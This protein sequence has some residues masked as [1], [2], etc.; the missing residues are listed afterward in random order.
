[1]VSELGRG[2]PASSTGAAPSRA[3]PTPLALRPVRVG[4]AHPDDAV[5]DFCSG[6][7][8]YAANLSRIH[9]ITPPESSRLT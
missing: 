9:M 1:M 2:L 3:K 4:R 5:A 8:R 7:P 6:T